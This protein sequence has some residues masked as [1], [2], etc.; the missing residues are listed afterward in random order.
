MATKSEIQQRMSTGIDAREG[1]DYKTG[2]GILEEV[3]QDALTSANQELISETANQLSIQYRLLAG[4][5][6]RENKQSLAKQ[7]STSSLDIYNQLQEKGF[8]NKH[9]VGIVRNHAH[10][11]LYS[12][13]VKESIPALKHSAKVQS[14]LGA[15]G[16]EL[17]HL[18]TALMVLGKFKESQEY[19]DKGIHL[20]SENNGSPIWLTFA[21]MAQASLYALQNNKKAS[22]FLDQVFQI[23][24]LENL[25]VREEEV[26]FLLDQPI[27]KINVLKAVAFLPENFKD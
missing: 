15:R 26:L 21:Y 10:A 27:N 8:Y 18:A 24:Q 7:Y 1:G 9:D 3:F 13:K 6:V 25:K 14:N 11:L 20:I 19:L 4:R 23:A 2:E 22:G 16:D 17:C 5:F 12:G